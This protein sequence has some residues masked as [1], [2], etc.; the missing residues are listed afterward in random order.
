MAIPIPVSTFAQVAQDGDGAGIHT[1]ADV[2]TGS[3]FTAACAVGVRGGGASTVLTAI[4]GMGI[5]GGASPRPDR[6]AL[7]SRAK[8][9]EIGNERMG[10]ISSL[11]GAIYA[12][13]DLRQAV[14]DRSATTTRLWLIESGLAAISRLIVA[15]APTRKAGGDLA[16][17]GHTARERVSQVA[18]DRPARYLDL[19]EQIERVGEVHMRERTIERT[20]ERRG[21]DQA[22]ISFGQR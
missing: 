13:F 15:V 14:V 9:N 7:Q 4:G 2:A 20:V 12:D 16:L 3:A 18:E 11:A 6:G 10:S 5:G 21:I 19:R 22:Q 17:I 8:I 1:G